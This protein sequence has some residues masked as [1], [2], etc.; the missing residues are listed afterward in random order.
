MGG[1]VEQNPD[2][3]DELLA[4]IYGKLPYAERVKTSTRK[5]AGIDGDLVAR[6]V[7]RLKQQRL[8]RAAAADDVPQRSPAQQAAIE[9]LKQANRARWAEAA[10]S[11]IVSPSRLRKQRMRAEAKAAR[12]AAREQRWREDQQRPQAARKP[13]RRT[14]TVKRLVTLASDFYGV[15]ELDMLG[16]S[17]VRSCVMARHAAIRAARDLIELS[18][19]QIGRRLCRDHSTIMHALKKPRDQ[20]QPFL[21]HV[22]E[23]LK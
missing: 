2:N 22:Q 16:D 19:L 17:R 1:E 12:I 5:V 7:E 15:R 10:E 18:L 14:L 9:K 8:E 13:Q 3:G 6:Y 4:R 20:F 21:D 11:G 23:Q